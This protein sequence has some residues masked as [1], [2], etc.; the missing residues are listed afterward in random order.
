V[1]VQYLDA[2]L[3]GTGAAAIYNLMEDTATAEICRAQ[4][5]QWV[6]HGATMEGGT[7]VDA[8]LYRSLRTAEVDRVAPE[9]T[10][11]TK[12]REAAEILDELVLN[13]EFVEFLT[14]PA[15]ERLQ[16]GQ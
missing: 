9:Q 7:P 15:Y 6:R 1:A 16:A 10:G 12:I 13:E 5:W 4:L 2:W 11:E 14:L 3:Q 8:A